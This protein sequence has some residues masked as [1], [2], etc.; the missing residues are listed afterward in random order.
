[1][2]EEMVIGSHSTQGMLHF[3]LGRAKVGAV[4]RLK[5]MMVHF[6]EYDFAPSASENAAV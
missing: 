1:M 2:I 3:Q 4:V 6:I 5:N